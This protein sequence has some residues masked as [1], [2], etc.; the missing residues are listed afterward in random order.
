MC[1]KSL[2]SCL[3]LC[4]PMDCRPTDS[5]VQEI[6]QARIL[7]CVAMPFSRGSSQPRDQTCISYTSC[8]EGG[9]FYHWATK[10][11]PK[12]Q[13]TIAKFN[14]FDYIKLKHF[15]TAKETVNKMKRQQMDPE[16]IFANM[17]SGKGL[18][19]NIGGSDCK[20]F[21]CNVGDPGLILGSGRSPGEGNGNPLQYSCLEN[22]MGRGA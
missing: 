9:F 3:T 17:P 15:Y 5:S 1:T 19:S 22:P 2:Q 18:I 7:C 14:K 10:E 12:T 11:V 8:T 13:A 16:K 6:L 20:E 4:D 21:V